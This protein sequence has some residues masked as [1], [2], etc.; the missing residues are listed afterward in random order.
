MTD[1][2]LVQLVAAGGAPY[3]LVA[4]GDMAGELDAFLDAGMD[5]VLADHPDVAAAAPEG[6]G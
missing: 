3:D 1:V 2:R 5:G 4:A 6:R